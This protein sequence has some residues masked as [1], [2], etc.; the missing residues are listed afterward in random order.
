M[1]SKRLTR[2]IFRTSFIWQ[3]NI[4]PGGREFG[5]AGE[6]RRTAEV[7]KGGFRGQISPREPT[8]FPVTH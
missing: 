5:N 6:C 3:H 8:P 7:P 4:R 1:S 2:K